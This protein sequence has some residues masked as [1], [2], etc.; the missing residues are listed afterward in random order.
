MAR[1]WTVLKPQE[2]QLCRR[3]AAVLLALNDKITL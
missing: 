3:R 1:L 2:R